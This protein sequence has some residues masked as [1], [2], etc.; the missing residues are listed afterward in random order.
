MSR[1]SLSAV[2]ACFLLFVSAG[3]Q[4]ED[5]AARERQRKLIVLSEKLIAEAAEFS[6]PENKAV[7]FAAVGQRLWEIDRK[8]AQAL[9]EQSIAALNSAQAEAE[10]E[11]SRNVH[12]ELITGQSIRPNLLRTIAVK[13]AAFALSN[14]HRTRPPALQRAF[15]GNIE[16]DRKISG[17]GNEAYLVQNE[18]ALEQHLARLAAEQDPAK[19]A[20][21]LKASLKKGI[22]GETLS[23]L[24]KLHEADAA[25]A[26]GLS[27]Q[28]V[29][30]L[31][32]KAPGSEGGFDY[33]LMQTGFAFLSDHIRERPE[34]DASFRFASADM[35]SLADRLIS[36][37]LEEVPRQRG[38]FY[39]YP[40]IQIAEK[41][42]PDAVEKL[43]NLHR[44]GPNNRVSI[45]DNPIVTKL[46][47][48]ETPVEKVLSEAEKLPLDTRRYVYSNVSNRLVAAGEMGRARQLIADNYS[49]EALETA[50]AELTR[51]H[52]YHTMNA[53]RFSE[54]E[55]LIEELEEPHCF[56][57]LI[58]LAD[59]I[60]YRNQKE[61][62][63][64]AFAVLER[65]RASMPSQPE[66]SS[67]MNQFI[68]LI[69]AYTRI[70][71]TA[72]IPAFESIIPTINDLTDASFKI[73][74][75]NGG[76]NIRRGEM[77]I[78]NGWTGGILT[79][80]S[81]VRGIGQ[82]DMDR[83]L[84]VIKGFTRRELRVFLY[85]QLLESF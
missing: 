28:I 2:L 70:E 25:E 7:V 54:A 75:Y 74:A 46:L 60:Y 57:A 41:M 34:T 23:L 29:N 59:A 76:H 81:V 21:L 51:Q 13:N 66:K 65:L 73:N 63:A 71:P 39:F 33:N 18:L 78:A 16:K 24:K 27:S 6:L 50:Q 32:R 62:K 43:R 67:E 17:S 56:S 19:A 8:R 36:L 85:Q 38:Q 68:Q 44:T 77:V 72:A 3:A 45:Y 55:A 1:V 79:D 83:T 84:E 20:E 31:I 40:L 12:N 35:K 82:I 22:S 80:G 9:F 47:D 49:D 48:N 30:E 64:Q 52:V 61:N 58:S 53:G 37:V 5:E 14:L 10:A 4:T 15:A 26:A 42:R 69:A 11:R